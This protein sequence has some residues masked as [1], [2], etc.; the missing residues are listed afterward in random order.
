MSLY[1]YPRSGIRKH[2]Q[3]NWTVCAAFTWRRVANVTIYRHGIKGML[4][5]FDHYLAESAL[6]LQL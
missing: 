3:R 5:A 4:L 6:R 1:S 2:N